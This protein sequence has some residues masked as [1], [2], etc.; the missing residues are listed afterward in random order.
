MLK[1]AEIKT[2]N[3]NVCFKG[4]PSR[5]RTE[6]NPATDKTANGDRQTKI[7]RLKDGQTI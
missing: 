4:G 5:D 2:S 1:E 7:A 6:H 3:A